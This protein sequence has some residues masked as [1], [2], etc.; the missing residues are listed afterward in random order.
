MSLLDPSWAHADRLL[1]ARQLTDAYLLA[2]AVHHRGRLVT[3]DR[4]LCGEAVIGGREALW[5]IETRAPS[6]Q[7]LG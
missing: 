4:R 7:H 6:N 1:E 2:L 3:F 5:L